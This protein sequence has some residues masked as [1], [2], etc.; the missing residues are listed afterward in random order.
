MYRQPNFFSGIFMDM[1]NN[2]L[3][4]FLKRLLICIVY[5]FLP[6]F[7]F[8][9][10][11]DCPEPSNKAQKLFQKASQAGFKGKEAYTYLIEAVQK[12]PKYVEALSALAY[13]NFERYK[14]DNYLYEREG[15]RALDYWEKVSQACSAYRNYESW[16]LLGKFHYDLREYEKALGYIEKYLAK[17]DP[18]KPNGIE[19][20][21]DMRARMKQYFD[22]FKN[23]VPFDPELV[24]G[25][26]T[27]DD[28]YLPM[29]SPDN[30]YLFYTR[31]T[32]V[33]TRSVYGKQ[34]KE[35]FMQSRRKYDGN[36]SSGIPMPEPFNKGR[37]QGGA[38]IS[39]DNKLL[40]I[41]VVEQVAMRDGRLFS[42]GDIYYSEFSN[43]HWSDLKSIGDHINGK[44]TWEGQPSISSDNQTLYFSSAR[45]EDNYGGMDLY[46]SEM[47]ENGQW[48]PAINL[49]PEVN[50]SGDEKSP[51]MHSDSHTLYFSS[52]GHPGVGGLDIFFSK[53]DDS[54][55]FS[56]P[57]NLGYPINSEEDEN[58]FMVS[59]DGK[60]GYFSSNP[61]NKGLDIY[62]F[63]LPEE[64]RPEEVVFVKGKIL[65]KNADAAVG[66][67]IELKNTET[68]EITKGVVDEESGEYVA[69]ITATEDQDVLMLAK[70]DG[71]AFT[72]KY[73]SSSEEVV[74]K[75]NY[76][77]PMAFNPI[78]TGSTYR[79]NNVNF[80]T[81]SYALNQQVKNILDEFIVFLKDNSSVKVRIQGH[82][83]NQGD[84]EEN[85]ILSR[86]RAKSVKEY[87][88]L[89]GID[90]GRLSYEGFGENQPIADNST[91]EGRAKNRRTEFVIVS[92]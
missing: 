75:P 86:Q 87:L 80:A 12:D 11:I 82:T 57:V 3:T 23:P 65:S 32:L 4:F 70:K 52:N 10:E 47:Q 36:Y 83:D 53:I 26:T 18:S 73:I 85:L 92:K 77:E 89:M 79:I 90:S 44:L 41:T 67:E 24:V 37:Y 30:Q 66:M 71:Y 55:K 34:T 69:V 61:E 62:N 42:N 22:I 88:V 38:S 81:S 7:L 54:G 29:L 27:N 39:V 74:G 6:S 40:F 31:K 46:K 20:A 2:P 21:E 78:E 45:G 60:Y 72:S 48:G 84:A 28:E 59:T 19:E 56:R 91:E 13:I 1:S 9:Q 25:P 51:F 16:Y 33:D 64:A 58:G 49:G 15:N 5:V 17:A 68:N 8:S 50:T 63:K 14:F 35:L 76:V 43:G